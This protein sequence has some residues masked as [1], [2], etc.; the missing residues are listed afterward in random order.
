MYG[1]RLMI[2][3]TLQTV[4]N[5]LQSLALTGAER[6]ALNRRACHLHRLRGRR[7]ARLAVIASG[8]VLRAV[9]NSTV[10][11]IRDRSASYL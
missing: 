9:N 7:Q 10:K 11:F 8:I 5:V 3:V 1:L 4:V 2:I 6:T